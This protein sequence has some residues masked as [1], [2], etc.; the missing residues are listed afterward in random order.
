MKKGLVVTLVA[1]VSMAFAGFASAGLPCAAYS[2][3]ELGF[4]INQACG[5]T[6]ISWSPNGAYDQIILYVTVNDC[7]QDPVASCQVRLDMSGS[8]DCSADVDGGANLTFCGAATQYATTDANGA[9]SFTLTGGGAGALVLDWTVTAECA[10]PEVEVCANSDTICTKSVDF[11]GSG[12][13]NFLD[14]FKYLPKLAAGVGYSADLAAC[15]AAN[16]V[17]FLDTFKYLP[18][19]GGAW[20]CSGGQ[21][22]I[23]HVGAS[24]F[25]CDDIFN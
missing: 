21:W 24:L 10:S 14:T 2:T 8:F 15:S 16:A 6:D 5:Q 4:S 12:G 25:E 3:C 7:L 19:L 20:T 22:T 18:A 17:N 11:N 13:I 9:A 1:I 23:T